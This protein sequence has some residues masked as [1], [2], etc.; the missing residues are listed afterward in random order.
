INGKPQRKPK[1]PPK[2][3]MKRSSFWPT[4]R[5]I[6]L[7]SSGCSSRWRITISFTSSRSS[8]L[9][10]IRRVTSRT[11]SGSCCWTRRCTS[12]R[13]RGARRDD[14]LPADAALHDPRDLLDAARQHVRER[15]QAGQAEALELE[16]VEQHPD[17]G[18]V[19]GI[20]D[21]AREDR[22]RHL[23]DQVAAHRIES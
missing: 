10:P 4:S 23:F 14:A 20:A 6:R 12:S 19:R 15:A 3:M 22:D 16:R 5:K 7:Q 1:M 13:T 2:R 11:M 8:M 18:P 21:E 9:C 17:A